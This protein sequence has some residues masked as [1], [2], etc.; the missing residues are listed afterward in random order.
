MKDL[1]ELKETTQH[2]EDLLKI[3]KAFEEGKKVPHKENFK[4]VSDCLEEMDKF[5]KSRKFFKRIGMKEEIIQQLEEICEEFI[6]PLVRIWERRSSF[7]ITIRSLNDDF[8]F[9]VYHGSFP[10]DSSRN[11]Y[12]KALELVKNIN[13][14]YDIGEGEK[15][16]NKIAYGW[17][18][19]LEKSH[20]NKYLSKVLENYLKR[21]D[22]FDFEEWMVIIGLSH[23]DL[24]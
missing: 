4:I 15:S 5:M 10:Y 17:N 1:R 21:N 14:Y 3:I 8:E 22:V 11:P 19:C 24:D 9:L 16:P 20:P 18:K 6:P 23:K 7:F 2:K 12:F 13:F